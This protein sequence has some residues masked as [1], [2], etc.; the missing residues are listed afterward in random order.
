MKQVNSNRLAFVKEAVGAM[1]W[2]PHALRGQQ[3]YQPTARPVVQTKHMELPLPAVRPQTM[4]AQPPPR[5]LPAVAPKELPIPEGFEHV[6][7][8][9]MWEPFTTTI[10][11]TGYGGAGETM[12]DVNT[13]AGNTS[14][15]E[16]FDVAKR[17]ATGRKSN[18]YHAKPNFA[19]T[20]SVDPKLIPYGSIMTVKDPKT[21]QLLSYV[22]GDTGQAVKARTAAAAAGFKHAV[23]DFFGRGDMGSLS[24]TIYPPLDKNYATLPDKS[25]YHR[26][27]AEYVGLKQPE[28]IATGAQG[29]H[30]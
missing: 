19:G 15:Q 6:V 24:A 22:A 1:S 10:R 21:G 13:S 16:V 9:P 14:T 3:P 17:V 8:K 30:L 4:V 26:R 23:G 11:A 2:G 27:A 18:L 20:V 29:P 28:Y 7:G 5:R 12:P 25:D